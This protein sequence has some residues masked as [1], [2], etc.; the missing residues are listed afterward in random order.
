[1]QND[2][3]TPCN[4]V[5]ANRCIRLCRSYKSITTWAAPRTTE[6]HISIKVA[7]V[8]SKM[9]EIPVFKDCRYKGSQLT[10]NLYGDSHK[11]VF[12]MM[13]AGLTKEEFFDLVA[14][15]KAMTLYSSR[16]NIFIYF[17]S[18]KISKIN[19]ESIR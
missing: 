3:V 13:A 11:F 15:L 10:K 1:M 17:E 8:L 7:V 14:T 16:H 12:E 18:S 6:I 2:L 4:S 5:V 9:I 19:K